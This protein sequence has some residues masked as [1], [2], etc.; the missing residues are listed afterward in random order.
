MAKKKVV[1]AGPGC[2]CSPASFIWL[3]IGVIILALGFFALVKGINMQWVGGAD[4]LNAGIWYA[5]GFLVLCIG[6]CVK[7]RGCKTCF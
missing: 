3:I 7:A 4:W 1:K 6:K 2:S 5:I